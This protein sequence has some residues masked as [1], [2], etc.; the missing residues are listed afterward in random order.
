MQLLHTSIESNMYSTI[1]SCENMTCVLWDAEKCHSVELL[2]YVVVFQNMFCVSCLSIY[3]LEVNNV[4]IVFF[5]CSTFYLNLKIQQKCVPA[6]FFQNLYTKV[7]FFPVRVSVTLYISG[8][9]KHRGKEWIETC[10]FKGEHHEILV[11][12]AVI[13][14]KNWSLGETR[15][16]RR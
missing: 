8:T 16:G 9:N 10:S 14:T 5:W 3:R 6:F 1:L 12:I 4:G 7:N 11:Y 2:S 13:C 15:N